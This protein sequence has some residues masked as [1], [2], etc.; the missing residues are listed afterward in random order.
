[1]RVEDGNDEGLEIVDIDPPGT[2]FFN[3]DFTD[4]PAQNGDDLNNHDELYVAPGNEGFDLDFEEEPGNGDPP[5]VDYD[6][7]PDGDYIEVDLSVLDEFEEC[8]DPDSNDSD[9][10]VNDGNDSIGING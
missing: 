5:A 7:T 3:P 8:Y 1:M 10:A 6:N 2:V 4:P 9:Y